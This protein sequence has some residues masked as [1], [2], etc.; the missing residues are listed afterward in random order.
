MILY[1]C[2]PSF[3]GAKCDWISLPIHSLP[4]HSFPIHSLPIHSFPIHSL[5]IHSLP[6]HSFPIH[7][8]PIHSLPVYSLPLRVLAVS[9]LRKT[10]ETG[11]R[12]WV[13]FS[14]EMRCFLPLHPS[15]LICVFTSRAHAHL[16]QSGNTAIKVFTCLYI[17]IEIGVLF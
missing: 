12:Q 11:G 3:F 17:L 8:L 6:I 15:F 2:I 14:P 16:G 1:G 9:W 10:T 5:P 13:V 7:S 4:I